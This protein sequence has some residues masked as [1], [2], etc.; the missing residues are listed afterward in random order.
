LGWNNFPNEAN[1]IGKGINPPPQNGM[2]VFR[3]PKP[4]KIGKGMVEQKT[5]GI[6]LKWKCLRSS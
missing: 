5:N 2:E 6:Q 1:K 3:N 4:K